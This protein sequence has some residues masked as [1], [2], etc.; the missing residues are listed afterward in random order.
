MPKGNKSLLSVLEPS[1]GPCVFTGNRDKC[2]KVLFSDESFSGVVS[3]DAL[4]NLIARK[5]GENLPGQKKEPVE[6]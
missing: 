4:W 5:N 1:E 3:W 2:V 6:K